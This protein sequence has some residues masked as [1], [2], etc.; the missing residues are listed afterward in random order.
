MLDRRRFLVSSATGVALGRGLL[1]GAA[2]QGLAADQSVHLGLAVDDINSLDPHSAV[3]SGDIAIVGNIF[4]ALLTGPG[5]D[6]STD[7]YL[8]ALAER[9]EPSADRKT[10]T[11]TL[12]KGVEW[13]HGFGAFSSED[14]KFSIERIAGTAFTSPFRSNLGGIE[15]VETDGPSVVRVRL[16]NPDPFFLKLAVNF[17]AGFVVCK[18]AVESGID[19]KTKPVGTGA[20]M[21]K[22]Y[23]PR[24]K[25][26][27]TRNDAYWGG[28]PAISEV[29]YQFMS[30]QSTRELALRAGDVNAI[31][32]DTRKDVV[33]RVR[34]TKATVDVTAS[35]TPYVLYIN[36]TK[37]P[38][39]DIRVRQA[40]AHATDRANLADFIGES[41]FL[42]EYS[43]V[44]SGYAGHT[45]G[46]RK[47]P[48]D[49]A[50][51]K[52][53]LAEAGFPNGFSTDVIISSS[54]IYLPIMQV[55]QAQWKQAG[56]DAALK[57]V[58]HPT[59][60][61][62]IRQD[63]SS[64]VIYNADR[65]PKTAQVYYDQFYAARA[66]IGK[67]TAITNFSHY[68]EAI[69]GIDD[70]LEVARAAT[71]ADAA[72]KAWIA[73]QKKVAE[74]LPSIPLGN[75]KIAVARSATLDIGY[76]LGDLPYYTFE[77]SRVL[78]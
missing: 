4:D 61:R 50:R 2:A 42:P 55:L 11:F 57:V 54:T 6:L 75:Q 74:D 31:D 53:L 18:K 33:N 30:Q 65:F 43:S 1:S 38:F 29:V 49:I 8:P 13:H 67:P 17:Q 78:V 3:V 44:P 47:Y 25:V 72:E 51:A 58:D 68:G 21:L 14:V 36:L 10:W 39:D 28:K 16:R 56:I 24:D 71:S 32:L 52:A 46:V 23:Q 45:D 60:H 48:H 77:H 7:N 40:L 69:P 66:A 73:A 22:S 70:L 37:K 62:M 76:T 63:L 26:I 15:A 34:R 27:L 35:G 5:G 12:R 41:L 64:L 19:M 20:F 9:W 59:F